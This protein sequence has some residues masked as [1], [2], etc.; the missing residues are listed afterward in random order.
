MRALGGVM[1][2]PEDL[3]ELVLGMAAPSLFTELYAEAG[4]MHPESFENG[5]RQGQD[6][7]PF[8]F[9]FLPALL[10]VRRRRQAALAIAG[11]GLAAGYDNGT[12]A[13]KFYWTSPPA[14]SGPVTFHLG[15][16]DGNGGAGT[17]E[18]PEDVYGDDTVQA[19][20]TVAELS[21]ERAMKGLP[22]E[23]EFPPSSRCRR[24][25]GI[26]PGLRV[27]ARRIR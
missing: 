18:V 23:T 24:G 4:T 17:S 6:V 11:I 3:M 16:V 25:P 10:L 9:A 12:I 22:T 21:I 2:E 15:A 20:I 27:A 5:K 1:Q 26:Q 8:A 13:W 14:G 7:S 19:H